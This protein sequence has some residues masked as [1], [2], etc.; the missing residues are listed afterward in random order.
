MVMH[1]YQGDVMEFMH[2]FLH[3]ASRKKKKEK[4]KRHQYVPARWPSA[5]CE[6]FFLTDVQQNAILQQ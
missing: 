2:F 6:D 4:K 5:A 3:P 1:V